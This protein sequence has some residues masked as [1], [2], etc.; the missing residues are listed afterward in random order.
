LAR[1][2]IDANN[3][4]K[5]THAVVASTLEAFVLQSQYVDKNDVLKS[6]SSEDSP[7]A[8]AEGHLELLPSGLYTATQ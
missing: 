7:F 2:D 6:L 1:A 3:V 8:T 4:I 5:T